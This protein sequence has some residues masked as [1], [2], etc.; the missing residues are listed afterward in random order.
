MV[1]SIYMLGILVADVT[2]VDVYVWTKSQVC[3]LLNSLLFISLVSDM[4]FKTVL[5]MFVSLQIIYLFK[6][7]CLWLRCV[8]VRLQQIFCKCD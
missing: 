2:N 5:L 3:L 1:N 7:Q 6:H 4:I 8:V